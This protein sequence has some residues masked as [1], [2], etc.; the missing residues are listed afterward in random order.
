[1]A[2]T[3]VLD[4]TPSIRPGMWERP[5][6]D[7]R[8]VWEAMHELPR[9]WPRRE[10]FVDALLARGFSRTL[11]QWLAMNLAA[12]PGG[13]FTLGLDLDEV[14][15]LLADS[16]AIDLWPAVEDPALPGETHHLIAERSDTVSPAD[17]ARLAGEPAERRVHAHVIAGAGHWLHIDAPGQVIDLIAGA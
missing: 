5:D 15:A 10:A 13:S 12:D 6:N 9:T 7:V 16:Y 1:L 11:A 4:S 14:R 17:R 8:E 2:Q 3:F